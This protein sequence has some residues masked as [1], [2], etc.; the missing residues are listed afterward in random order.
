MKVELAYPGMPVG[1]HA[2][3]VYLDDMVG[4]LTAADLDI[5]LKTFDKVFEPTDDDLEEID[6]LVD[7]LIADHGKL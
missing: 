5:A 7:A 6:D 3:G 1:E 4:D 2:K